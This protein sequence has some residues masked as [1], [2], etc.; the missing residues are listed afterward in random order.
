MSDKDKSNGQPDPS[1]QYSS[2][3]VDG[4]EQAPSRA[5]LRAVGFTDED[6]EGNGSDRLIDAIIVWGNED[7]IAARIKE[8]ED[9]GATQVCVQALNPEGS[10]L[11]DGEVICA[12]EPIFDNFAKV[13]RG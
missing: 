3:V 11:E 7:T 5:M 6:F 1:R 12:N 10:V 2:L 8:H 9:A 4:V 13:I